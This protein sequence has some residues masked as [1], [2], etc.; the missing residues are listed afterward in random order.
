MLVV[1]TWPSWRQSQLLEHENS[2]MKCNWFLFVKF[3]LNLY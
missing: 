3:K 1:T 2:I